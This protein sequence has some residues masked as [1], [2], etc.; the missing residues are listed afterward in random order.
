MGFMADIEER[1]EKLEGNR[2]IIQAMR[3][4]TENLAKHQKWPE[5]TDV[6]PNRDPV[7]SNLKVEQQPVENNS[8]TGI[9]HAAIAQHNFEVGLPPDLPSVTGREF[10]LSTMMHSGPSAPG[11][12]WEQAYSEQI[13]SGF[14]DKYR[15]RAREGR[16]H[17][18]SGLGGVG[19]TGKGDAAVPAGMIEALKLSRV[20][21]AESEVESIVS[22]QNS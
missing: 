7:N 3:E 19:R 10:G 13:N 2:A 14:A 9:S 6:P 11:Y 5:V 4:E 22:E 15:R 16:E 8:K 17:G 21:E 18:A 1:E 12:Q 20:E